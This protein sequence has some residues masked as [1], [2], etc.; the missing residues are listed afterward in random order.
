MDYGPEF[1][2]VLDRLLD[3]VA[4]ELADRIEQRLDR[5]ADGRQRGAGLDVKQAAL[6]LGVSERKMRELVMSGEVPS[7]KV[8]RR[9]LISASAIEH[10]L[11]DHDVDNGVDQGNSPAGN[12]RAIGPLERAARR[13]RT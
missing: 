9:R 11:A 8:G 4:K 12:W 3:Q 1:G 13:R 6:R 5:I 2:R 7:I 10:L